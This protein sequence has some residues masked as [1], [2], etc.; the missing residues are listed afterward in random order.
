MYP[1]SELDTPPSTPP[2]I[3]IP[4][5][6]V[7]RRMN[8]QKQMFF[9]TNLIL[10]H[11]PY[12]NDVVNTR[13]CTRPSYEICS[14]AAIIIT[15]I[16][17]QLDTNDLLYHSKSPMIAYALV[18]AMRVHIMNATSNSNNDKLEPDQNYERSSVTLKKLP[19]YRNKH[20]LLY[21]ALADLENQYENR[22]ILAKEQEDEERSKIVQPDFMISAPDTP[23]F[24][25]LRKRTE[26][27]VPT[28]PTGSFPKKFKPYSY[29]NAT[30]SQKTKPI[31]KPKKNTGGEKG[32]F[33]I[34]LKDFKR[35]TIKDK[36]VPLPSSSEQ[37]P[38]RSASSLQKQQQQQAQQLQLQQQQIQQ[39]QQQQQEQQQQEHQQQKQQQLQQQQQQQILQQQQLQQQEHQQ[40][41]QE[42]QQQEQQQQEQRQQEQL[43]QEQLR[44]QQQQLQQMQQQLLLQQYQYHSGLR[45]FEQQQIESQLPTE[46]FS[47]TEFEVPG[48]VFPDRSQNEEMELMMSNSALNLF[49]GGETST[50]VSGNS[51][52]ASTDLLLGFISNNFDMNA[53]N[54]VSPRVSIDQSTTATTSTTA[55]TASSFASNIN[56]NNEWYY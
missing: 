50:F 37:Q 21:N 46:S 4:E 11:R 31:K 45:Q 24:V 9:Y 22:F 25:S 55:A 35:P 56:N 3:T 15:D 26:S 23:S 18:M 33:V 29:P 19:Q 32:Q 13:G 36:E 7:A 1:N 5:T 8:F 17:S 53:F 38:T 14:Y 2:N 6:Q 39:K 41:Q 12:V 52:P 28:E 44:L 42:Q 27:P 49:S 16:A 54:F 40:R 43:Q 34:N 10:L 47:F 51:S 20:S 30:V 48:G